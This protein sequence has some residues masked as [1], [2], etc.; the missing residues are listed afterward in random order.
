[1][2][3]ERK[4]ILTNKT[5]FEL[6][7]N[8]QNVL[9]ASTKT[10]YNSFRSSKFLELE[11]STIDENGSNDKFCEIVHRSLHNLRQEYWQCLAIFIALANSLLNPII[12]A[13]WYREFRQQLRRLL[14]YLK[15]NCILSLRDPLCFRY[16]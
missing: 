9:L 6:D 14:R 13:F 10:N 16:K 12:Y 7:W 15:L 3:E 5:F 11:T 1:M 2:T 8:I 4:V